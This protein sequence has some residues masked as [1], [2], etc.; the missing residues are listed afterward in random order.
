MFE[1]REFRLFW[2]GLGI[3]KGRGFGKGIGIWGGV[4]VYG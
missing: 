3:R 2:A 4:V 1:V